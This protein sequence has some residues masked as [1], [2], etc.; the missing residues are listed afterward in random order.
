MKKQFSIIFFLSFLFA[1]HTGWRKKADSCYDPS[2]VQVDAVCP[3]IYAPVCGCDGKTYSNE[4][5][6]SN[7]GIL[8]WTKG[9]CENKN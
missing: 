1:C 8:K 5:V 7:Q 6:A 3:M 4:C 2:R 9:A